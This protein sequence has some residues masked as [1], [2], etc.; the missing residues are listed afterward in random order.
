MMASPFPLL[1]FL[2]KE[3]ALISRELAAHFDKFLTLVDPC[4]DMVL[5]L[6]KFLYWYSMARRLLFP[7]TV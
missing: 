2:T 4:K 5:A 3:F 7:L 6:N 1:D